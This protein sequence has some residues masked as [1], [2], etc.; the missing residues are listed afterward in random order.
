MLCILQ[1]LTRAWCRVST[2]TASRRVVSPPHA[3]HP[4]PKPCT[5]CSGSRLPSFAVS[6]TSLRWSGTHVPFHTGFSPLAGCIY[7]PPGLAS[8]LTSLCWIR[9]CCAWVSH[10][11]FLH[12]PVDGH[13]KWRDSFCQLW[14]KLLKNI[15]V[16]VFV[17]TWFQPC[18]EILDIFSFLLCI[19]CFVSLPFA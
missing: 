14:I 19:A 18:V 8:E 7:G 17:W 15:Q 11:W 4:T 1:V 3:L 2:L 12:S 10:G 6:R 16:Q 5:H 9:F 13:Q